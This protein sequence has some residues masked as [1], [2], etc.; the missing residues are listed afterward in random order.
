M[1]RKTRL[2]TCAPVRTAALCGR[3][4]SGGAAVPERSEGMQ[5][6]DGTT[7][8][9]IFC[10]LRKQ[11]DKKPPGNLKSEQTQK[12]KKMT[13]RR[14]NENGIPR[15]IDLLGQVLQ[16]HAEIRPDIFIPGT[17]K[18]MDAELSEMLKDGSKPIYVAAS[19]RE[20]YYHTWEKS[21]ST[22]YYEVDFLISD[23]SKIDALEI[24]S[25]GTGKH[26]SIKEFCRKFSQN[27]NRAYL[28]SQKDS[29]NEENLLLK[30][31]YL[32]PFLT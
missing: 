14:A 30:P 31:F 17:T 6:K 11:T 10:S 26:E 19:G 3:D 23:G 7:D 13:I 8:S 18:Y 22:H 5:A 20:L 16:I 2:F 9:P 15:I 4:R 21:G 27:I 32:V 1:L 12:G 28:I 25:S 24:K 29:G